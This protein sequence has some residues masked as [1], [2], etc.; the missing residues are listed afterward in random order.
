MVVFVYILQCSDDSLYTGVSNN[1]IKRFNEH[2]KGK[3]SKYV[4]SRLPC[5]LV[6]YEECSNRSEALKR[7]ALIKSKDRSEKLDLIHGFVQGL[8]S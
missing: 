3:G 7:E 8:I 1:L 5:K 2:V 6:Y 4:R